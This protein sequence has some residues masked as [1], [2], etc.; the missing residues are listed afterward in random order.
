MDIR[1]DVYLSK[2]KLVESREKAQKLI[3]ENKVK[4]NGQ[5]VNKPSRKIS[6]EDIVELLEKEKYVSRAAYK[7]KKALDY[8]NIDVQNKNC[9]DIGSS[10]G[11]F[12]Q[13]LLEYGA[14]KVYA[15]D[16]G[17]NQ[18][19]EKL[20]KDKRIVIMENTN[21][22]YLNKEDFENVEIFTCDVSFISV[23]KL[24]DSIYNI[25]SENAEGIILIKPQFEL[26]PLKLVKGVVK[27]DIYRHEAI[28][29][30]K[31]AFIKKGFKIIGITE[32]PVKGK[33]GNIEY[34]LYLKK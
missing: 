4:V 16:S 28:E 21:A 26:D 7:L 30:V 34:L 13:V 15:V 17:T 5:I 9:I 25:T 23:T 12:T 11:G 24:I 31:S 3:K 19:H 20:R 32:S 8:F 33:E 1:L 22:R 27:K 2:N 10:T 18:L 14:N 6:D 29:K